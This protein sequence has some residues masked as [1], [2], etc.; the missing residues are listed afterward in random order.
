MHT[1]V[2]Y[3]THCVLIPLYNAT[4]YNKLCVILPCQFWLTRTWLWREVHKIDVV[5]LL[6]Q[7]TKQSKALPRERPAEDKGRNI[8]A[9]TQGHWK[10]VLNKHSSSVCKF[11]SPCCLPKISENGNQWCCLVRKHKSKHQWLC[12]IPSVTLTFWCQAAPQIHYRSL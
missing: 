11:H 4:V 8:Y 9:V 3:Y 7:I 6:K 2:L 5:G 10:C 1:S 12:K